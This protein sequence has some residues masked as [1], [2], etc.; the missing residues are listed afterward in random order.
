MSA[1]AVT[2]PISSTSLLVNLAENTEDI[3]VLPKL[4]GA[5]HSNIE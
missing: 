3:E 2:V 1:N 4:M 5:A